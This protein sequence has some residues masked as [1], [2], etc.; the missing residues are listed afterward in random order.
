MKQFFVLIV[1]VMLVLRVQAQ[2]T[3]IPTGTTANIGGITVS[4][5]TLILVGHPDY[6]AKYCVTTGDLTILSSPG[7]SGYA[8]FCFQVVQDSYYVLS[9]QVGAYDHNYI[10]KSSD[11]GATWDTLFHTPGLFYT[12]SIADSTFGVLGG[13]FGS[14]AI[15]DGSDTAWVLD[16][17]AGGIFMSSATYGDSTAILEGTGYTFYTNDRE[18]SW[19]SYGQNYFGTP[20]GSPKQTQFLGEDTIFSLSNQSGTTSYFRRLTYNG[21]AWSSLGTNIDPCTMNLPDY[22]CN[23]SS[24]A[25]Q[26][27]PDGSGYILAYVES[28]LTYDPY[29]G[30]AVDRVSIFYTQDYGTSWAS[31]V[32]EI[33]QI[34]YCMAFLNDTTAFIAGENGLLYRWDLTVPIPNMLGL[35]KEQSNNKYEVYPN[36]ASDYIYVSG[37]EKAPLEFQI[38]A[39][40]GQLIQSG[41]LENSRVDIVSI[42]SGQYILKLSSDQDVYV[43]RIVK[44]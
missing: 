23:S 31:Y 21:S 20:F 1:G 6:F 9:K 7:I 39:L 15:T 26:M 44:E 33:P 30:E 3:Q 2:F 43:T 22:N 37:G 14:H 38:F 34:M 24:Y 19:G 13:A 36:P 12:L 32:T 40:T 18:F 8:N 42:P 25:M 16:T 11:N 35:E 17:I 4:G 28:T 41:V 27:N 29:H 10:L 5:D